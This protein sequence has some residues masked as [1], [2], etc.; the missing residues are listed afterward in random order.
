[1][2]SIAEKDL[3]THEAA[4]DYEGVIH[5]RGQWRVAVCRHD[6]Q[7]LLQRRSGDGSMAGPRWR[8]VAFCR[9]RAA[10]VRLWQAE[11]GDE[12]KALASLPDSINIR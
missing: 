7:W 12:G 3:S 8:S 9:T 1:M 5:R 6:L 10:L 4:D 2:T 11:T